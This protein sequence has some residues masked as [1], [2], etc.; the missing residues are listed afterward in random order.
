MMA[1][2]KSNLDLFRI[3]A[4]FYIVLSSHQGVTWHQVITLKSGFA[5]SKLRFSF[6]NLKIV[7]DYDLN[8]LTVNTI[9]LNITP[10]LTLEDCDQN[11]RK[12]RSNG[13]MKQYTDVLAKQFNFTN[14]SHKEVND[15]W[16][17][18]PKSEPHNRS[19]EWGGVLGDVIMSKYDL[20]LTAWRWTLERYGFISCVSI[21]SISNVLIWTPK[22][23][24]TDFGLFVRPFTGESWIAIF[25]T[26]T[27]T[28]IVIAVVH[29]VMPS[30]PE[31]IGQ[32][33][34]ITTL[35]YFF[36]LLNAFYGGAMTM[37]F[38]SNIDNQF[39]GEI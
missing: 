20:S 25:G 29:Y 37:F 7:E 4:L 9:G 33:I 14:E 16:G 11:G 23:K 34:M 32:N 1:I 12:C 18:L 10:Y 27:M 6:D 8:G 13:Y 31:R 22:I 39:E 19:S 15:D 17:V 26:T 5:I 3:D 28:T 35:W 21:I 30:G 36:V 24:D 38:S 2:F